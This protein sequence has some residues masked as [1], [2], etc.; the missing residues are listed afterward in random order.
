M[1]PLKV[2]GTVI[3]PETIAALFTLGMDHAGDTWCDDFRLTKWVSMDNM[4]APPWRDPRLFAEDFRFV[5]YADGVENSVNRA[6]VEFALTKMCTTQ[7]YEWMYDKICD[8]SID[9]RSADIFLQLCVFGEVVY[10]NS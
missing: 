10:E 6:D 9:V 4:L 3:P 2:N 7:E 8:Q 5:F 1:K